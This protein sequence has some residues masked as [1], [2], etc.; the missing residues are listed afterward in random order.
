[1]SAILD[2]CR[3]TGNVVFDADYRTGSVVDRSPYAAAATV[4]Q[5]VN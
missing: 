1:M 2:R 5:P 3:L 4:T